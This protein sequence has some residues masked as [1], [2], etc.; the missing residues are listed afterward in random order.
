M[1]I[2]LYHNPQCSK[3][4]QALS[5][6]QEKDVT[7]TII[8]YLKTPLTVVELAALAQKLRLT[9][10]E[11]MRQHEAI[12]ETENLADPILTHDA[13]LQAIVKHP[14]LLERPIAVTHDRAV[15]GRPP[16]NVLTLLWSKNIR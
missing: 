12:Y 8:D 13:L 14:R 10:R 4:R 6:L 16:E 5:I 7:L 15:I 9:P 1:N 3:S 2:T 11:F